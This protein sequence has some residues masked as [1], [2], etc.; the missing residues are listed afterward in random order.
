MAPPNNYNINITDHPT[1]IVIIKKLEI[2]WE[3]PK[4]DTETSNEQM[5]SEN[6][7]HGLAEHR[8]ATD[9][10]F[11]KNAVSVKWSTI[12]WNMPVFYPLDLSYTESGILK[13]P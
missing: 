4:C 1:N 6:G 11:I 13:S 2:L 5:Q 7:A 9:L 8:I 3:F 12:K 10:Q